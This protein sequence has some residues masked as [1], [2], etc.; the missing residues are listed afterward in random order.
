MTC[1]G[2]LW[3][4]LQIVLIFGQYGSLHARYM[5]NLLVV[6]VDNDTDLVETK[7][8][9]EVALCPVADEDKPG[10][11]APTRLAYSIEVFDVCKPANE[12]FI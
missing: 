7:D 12:Y 1:S 2:R 8:D 11:T 6:T 9:P 4:C 10:S 5:K 3:S